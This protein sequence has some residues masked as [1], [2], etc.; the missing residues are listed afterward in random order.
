YALIFFAP[1]CALGLGSNISEVLSISVH[2]VKTNAIA[3]GIA[4][5][6]VYGDMCVLRGSE[7]YACIEGE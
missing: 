5:V 2:D 4:H 6:C 7:V 1:A 3:S